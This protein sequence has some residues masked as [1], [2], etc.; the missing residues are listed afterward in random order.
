MKL[1]PTIVLAALCAVSIAGPA[2]AHECRCKYGS[3]ALALAI[4]ATFAPVAAVAAVGTGHPPFQPC[5]RRLA[6]A[7][8]ATATGRACRSPRRL[9]GQDPGRQNDF[10]GQAR[11]DHDRHLRARQP[12]NVLRDQ[13]YP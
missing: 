3:A 4:G 5:L 2:S 8:T 1:I 10:L 12:R 7:C 13:F 9:R 6:A 11:H